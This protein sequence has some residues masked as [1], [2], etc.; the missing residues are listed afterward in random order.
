MRT[1]RAIAAVLVGIL[2]VS[3]A[4]DG[5]L[6]QY[7]V[8]LRYDLRYTSNP[9]YIGP[10]SYTPPSRPDP[11]A[12]GS[13]QY[14]NLELTGNV[15]AGRS[16]QGNVPYNQTGS[17][18][19]PRLP[20]MALS[21]FYRD[22]IGIG[23]L[24]TG[25]EYGALT[26][27]FPG[28]GSVTDLY[29]AEMRFAT[30]MPGAR[31]PYTLPNLNS[32]MPALPTNPGPGTFYIPPVT[33]T[34][35]PPLVTG[36]VIP[37]SALEAVNA[38]M[39]EGGPLSPKPP[40][41]AAPSTTPKTTETPG[42]T[43]KQGKPSEQPEWRIGPPPAPGEAGKKPETPGLLRPSFYN[44]TTQPNKSQEAQDLTQS[45]LYW[46]VRE[47]T[48]KG[49]PLE[50]PGE[51]KKP[52]PPAKP[53]AETPG[54]EGEGPPTIPLM[55]EKYAPPGTYDHYMQRADAAMAQ[56]NFA[57]A[58]SLYQAAS[59]QA[60]DKSLPVFGRA[61]ALLGDHQ[62]MYAIH[63]LDRALRAHP[64]WAVEAPNLRKALPKADAFERI[65]GDLKSDLMKAPGNAD[66][67]FALGFLYYTVGQKDDALFYLH[68]LVRLRGNEPG[69]ELAILNVLEAP[70]GQK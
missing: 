34:G 27:Y 35:L 57:A 52:T 53:E 56:N 47:A 58:D 31:A 59:T 23:D 33:T 36:L 18:I 45:A 29:T 5:V 37:R 19:T 20:S 22:S 7:F 65:T 4:A 13:V 14:G 67:C 10:S 54:T 64:N 25:V 8:P 11:Y 70:P 39:V 46:M 69:P 6:A 15:R 32:A 49:Q 16:F 17:Q 51:V 42:A 12:F 55:P 1:S 28:S 38:M 26:P 21:N 62:Y 43:E 50:I 44:D 60:T 3:L 40:E 66:L 61:Y 9:G 68:H 63:V 48:T 41:A 2:A 30:P 24:G